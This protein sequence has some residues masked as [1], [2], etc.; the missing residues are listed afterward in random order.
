MD[1]R[2]QWFSLKVGVSGGK[3]LNIFQLHHSYIGILKY[4]ILVSCLF[5]KC[6]FSKMIFRF[7][8]INQSAEKHLIKEKL[9]WRKTLSYHLCFHL[10]KVKT[11]KNKKTRLT[12]NIIDLR[13]HNCQHKM[14]K[15]NA[16]LNT[17]CYAN[18]FIISVN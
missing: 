17:L 2:R 7:V 12:Q 9:L 15:T 14:F 16:A 13:Q 5:S 11:R 18:H 8:C 6:Y 1:I 3:K 10:S 4:H